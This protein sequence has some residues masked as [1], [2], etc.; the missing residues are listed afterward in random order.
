MRNRQGSDEEVS[1]EPCAGVRQEGARERLPGEGDRGAEAGAE[2]G[3]RI[4]DAA[5][6]HQG[7]P[8]RRW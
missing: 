2:G 1:V 3:A 5:Q 7:R 4:Q 6:A 8:T